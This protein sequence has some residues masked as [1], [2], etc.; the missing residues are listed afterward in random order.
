M[1]P[2]KAY[3]IQGYLFIIVA[4]SAITSFS[5]KGAITRYEYYQCFIDLQCFIYN[6]KKGDVLVYVYWLSSAIFIASIVTVILLER[7][8]KNG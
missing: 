7:S 8:K 3:K 1:K 5:A 6:L 4:L 2:E